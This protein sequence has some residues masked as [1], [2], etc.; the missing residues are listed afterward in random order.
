MSNLLYGLHDREG[1]FVLP[2]GGWCVDTVAL[3]ENPQPT[4]YTTLRGDINWI[5]RL[6]WGYGTTGTI[7]LPTEYDRMAAACALY[8]A[9]SKGAARF[10]IGNEP[11]HEQERPGGVY[12]T[13]DHYAACFVKCRAAIK[14]AVP[15][16]Q[17]IPAPCAP[18]HADPTDWGVYWLD[19]LKT[20]A[21]TGGCDG[22][23]VHAYTRSSNPADVNSTAKMGPP[24]ESTYSGFLTFVDALD[25]VPLSMRHLPAYITE[26]NEL[27]PDGWHDANT[28][29]VQAAYEE[30][31]LWNRGDEQKIHALVLYRWPQ[32]DKW[33]IEGKQGVIDDFRAAIGR[34]YTSPVTGMQDT[35]TPTTTPTQ[36]SAAPDMPREW[37]ERLT[38][39]GVRVE[40]PDLAPG[41]RYWRVIKARW[42]SESEAGGRHHIYV[43]GQEGAPWRVQWPSGFDR[44]QANGRSGFDASNFP[45]SPS[46]NEFSV[47]VDNGA[48]SERIVGIGMGANGNPGIHTSTLV[49]FA[50]ATVPQSHTVHIPVV[51][52]GDPPTPPAPAAT[53]GNDWPRIYAFIRKWEGGFVD[54]PSDPGGA[55]NKGITI[56]TFIRWRTGRGLP[57]PTVDDLRNITDA[58]AEQ[59]FFEWY[60]KASGAD[61]LP[62]PLN[63]AQADTAV[64]AGV[65]RAQEML[66]KSNGDFLAYMG[67]LIDW[68]TR[69]QNFEHFGRAWIRRRAE[70]LLEAAK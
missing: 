57:T 14:R 20:I 13:P 21:R 51:E 37:D 58:E 34:G 28:G 43:E 45:M 52:T 61:R 11:N 31:N 9:Q 26:C 29:V 8:V 33:H 19:M 17:V 56:G 46:M 18:Y 60:Y 47:Q 25:L 41:A 55:T 44:K 32:F 53:P 30:I 12:I 10:I 36:P 59:I 64:N 35:M 67:H 23:A 68:Y 16:A 22:I 3:S 7:P 48:P 49:T 4:N 42:F 65:G 1:R 5:V 66:A 40:T 50:L 39:R 2:P 63:L 70:I 69:I 15:S 54:H 24:L 27:L 6:N 38:Q 62:W